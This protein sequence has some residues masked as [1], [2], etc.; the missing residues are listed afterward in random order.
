MYFVDAAGREAGCVELFGRDDLDAQT[1]AQ[2]LVA[3]AGGELWRA[4][5]WTTAWAA[6]SDDA[7]SVSPNPHPTKPP[8]GNRQR[9]AHSG[10]T[11][12]RSS[13]EASAPSA[14]EQARKTP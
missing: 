12:R 1:E 8:S 2:Q 6:E 5:H 9:A 4:P 11:R 14:R 7:G 13:E 10:W 3:Q